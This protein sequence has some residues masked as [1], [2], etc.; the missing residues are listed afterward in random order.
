MKY[1]FLLIASCMI[2]GHFSCQSPGR[3][4]NQS[5]ASDTGYTLTGKIA[6]IDSGW[7]Y[8]LHR[9]SDQA[10]N[11]DSARIDKGQ[12]V[13]TGR[14]PT[15]EFCN[16]GVSR[17]G[18]KEFAFGFFIGHGELNLTVNKDSMTDAQV[19]ITGSGSATE[20]EFRRFQISQKGVDSAD[21]AV[22]TYYVAAR[23]NHD[24]KQMDS[25]VA[26][27]Q[28]LGIRHRQLLKEFVK[29]NPSSYVSGFEV[30]SNYSYN[31]DAR[32]LDS[33]YNGLD[34]TIRVSFYGKKIKETLA[35]A[36][37]TAIGK[38]APEFTANTADGKAIALSSFRGKYTLVDFWASW[39]G[40]CR[41]E[42]PAVVKAYRKYHPKGFAILGV[43]LDETKPEWEQ[44]IRK[45]G[46]SWTQVSDLK[47]WQSSIAA[48]YGVKGIPMNF[49]LD[50]DGK[51][52]GK[53]LRGIDLENKLAESIND[54][55]RPVIG[56][57]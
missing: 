9:Q 14:A 18:G 10:G 32:E 37:L 6:G 16:L 38:P 33:L 56:S 11:I 2:F 22:N 40:P 55:R 31:P 17:N 36:W 26:V 28:Q 49:L 1:L 42:N 13:F 57:R 44:A 24:Q 54:Q 45:D 48:L 51:I 21:E 35:S 4:N 5:A 20:D 50:K 29:R 43:S 19:A 53:G 12:F 30:Y 8:L 3:T 52:I 34:T 23:A 39:C 15:P 7:A 47:G 27:F 25:L 41:A 46:L